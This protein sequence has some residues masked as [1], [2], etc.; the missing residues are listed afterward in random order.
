MCPVLYSM[1]HILGK[2]EP[3]HLQQLAGHLTTQTD[4]CG[5]GVVL[6]EIFW[7]SS[8]MK[9]Y[10]DEIDMN[11]DPEVDVKRGNRRAGKYTGENQTFK[12]DVT[13]IKGDDLNAK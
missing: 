6:L 5:F 13:S 3:S 8:A 7:G 9:N 10:S 1:N 11:L 12:S 4:V 2:N